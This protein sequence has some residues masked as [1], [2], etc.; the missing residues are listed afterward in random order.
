MV[1]KDVGVW[2]RPITTFTWT[3]A[4][5]CAPPEWRA[6]SWRRGRL[7]AMP[8]TSRGNNFTGIRRSTPR[9]RWRTGWKELLN[10]RLAGE[11]VA[12]IIGEWEFYGLPLDISRDVLIPRMDTELL[13]ERAILLARAAGEGARVLDSVRRQRL[14]GSGGGRQ[15]ARLSGG[16]GRRQRGGDRGLQAQCPPQRFERPGGLRAGRRAPDAFVRP[17]GL[18]RHCL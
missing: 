10:R 6:R 9:P 13:A 18:R 12:Y 8:P 3:P 14:C 15:C 16:A 11:P 4:S 1:L 5:A 17:L 2:L 7:S